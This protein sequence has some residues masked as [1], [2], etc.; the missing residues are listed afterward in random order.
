MNSQ[1]E[2]LTI[3]F[4]FV[5]F[6]AFSKLFDFRNKGKLFDEDTSYINPS[7]GPQTDLQH[8]GQDF[9]KVS[10]DFDLKIKE[11]NDFKRKR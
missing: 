9:R 5:F 2:N 11:V 7:L 6:K 1:K 8:I 3:W 4:L 10:R